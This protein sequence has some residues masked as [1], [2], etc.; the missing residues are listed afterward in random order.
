MDDDDS[1]GF[2]GA[3][4]GAGGSNLIDKGVD[5]IQDVAAAS[6]KAITPKMKKIAKRKATRARMYSAKMLGIEFI[7]GLSYFSIE[8]GTSWYIEQIIDRAYGE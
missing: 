6:R 7:V 4:A 3:A 5:I 1:S 8:K 2:V